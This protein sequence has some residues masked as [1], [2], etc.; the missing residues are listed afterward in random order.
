MSL[1]LLG[2]NLS[3]CRSKQ[4]LVIRTNGSE[5][6]VMNMKPVNAHLH[7][8]NFSRKGRLLFS[9]YKISKMCFVW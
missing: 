7:S 5:E 9:M 2:I 4:C 3:A 1:L 8:V 6:M